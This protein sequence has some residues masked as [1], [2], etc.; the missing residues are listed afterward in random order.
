[1]NFEGTNNLIVG[2]ALGLFTLG[3]SSLYILKG[4]KNH[5]KENKIKEKDKKREKNDKV[6]N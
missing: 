4:N 2:G 6:P 3:L 1:M 5:Q